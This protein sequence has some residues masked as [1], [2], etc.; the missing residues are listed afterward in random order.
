MPYLLFSFS[1]ICSLIDNNDTFFLATA[2]VAFVSLT[3][4][5]FG[6]ADFFPDIVNTIELIK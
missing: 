1:K 2:D 3:L 4:T 6:C 5:G